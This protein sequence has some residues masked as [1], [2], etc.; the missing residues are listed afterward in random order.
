MTLNSARTIKN[1][2]ESHHNNIQL[3][4][5]SF[6]LQNEDVLIKY[7]LMMLLQKNSIYIQSK[8]HKSNSP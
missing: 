5:A 8:S 3:C 7:F 4:D 2:S 1:E 6:I